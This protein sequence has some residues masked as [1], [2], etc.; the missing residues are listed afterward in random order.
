MNFDHFFAADRGVILV[1]QL[2]IWRQRSAAAAAISI[3]QKTGW[4]ILADALSGVRGYPGVI[5]HADAI[6]QQ[7]PEAPERLLHFGESYVSKRVSQ[8]VKTVE[9]E[10][11]WQVHQHS[12]MRDPFFQNPT[13]LHLTSADFATQVPTRAGSAWLQ[14]WEDADQ[15]VEALCV[16]EWDGKLTEPSIARMV[17]RQAG[18]AGALFVGNSMPVRDF[19]SFGEVPTPLVI[20]GNRGA[21]GIDGNLATA[22]G[23]AFQL[24]KPVVALVGDLTALHDLNSLALLKRA[25]VIVVVVNNHGGGIFRFLPLPVPEPDLRTYWETPHEL[26]FQSAAAQFGLEWQQPPTAADFERE[27]SDAIREGHSCIL[28]VQTDRAENLAQH[29]AFGE[30]VKQ[31]TLWKS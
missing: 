19:D 30:K 9:G 23:A 10:N 14:V 26:N 21:S 6:L 16:Q 11:Y 5:Q 1:G 27:L 29:R 8:W 13:V 4:P 15:A 25:S 12:E 20:L 18:K 2:P 17:A 28:E 3:S 31:L 7:P 24:G 22:A